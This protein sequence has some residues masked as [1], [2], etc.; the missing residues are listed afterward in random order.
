MKVSGKNLI[1][2][3]KEG[4]EWRLYACA[5]SAQITVK[6]DAIETTVSGDGVFASFLPSKISFTGTITGLASIND[7]NISLPELRRKQLDQTIFKMRFFRV[8]A[9][10]NEYTEEAYFFITS[11]SDEGAFD[12]MDTFTVE[13]QGTGPLSQDSAPPPDTI[14]FDY[15]FGWV[16]I[17][18]VNTGPDYVPLTEADFI[19]SL[20]N[21]FTD[22]E[23]YMATG[24]DT[25]API[26][27]DDFHN[28]V[29]KVTFLQVPKSQAAFAKW[30]EVGNPFQQN[31]PIDPTYNYGSG[32]VWFL[33]EIETGKWT[34]LTYYQTTFTGS[35]IFST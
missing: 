10:A 13:V 19:A 16:G 28:T 32:A 18:T 33:S 1:V 5:I 7:V 11:S 30:T 8:D 2:Y 31:Q 25:D 14:P 23:Q 4:E 3:I 6:T 9:A 17:D 35:L 29:D 15:R 34:Y 20:D 27:V 22:G 24:A 26:T 21:V 12:G